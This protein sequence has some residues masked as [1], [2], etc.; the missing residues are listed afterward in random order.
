[1]SFVHLDVTSDTRLLLHGVWCALVIFVLLRDVCVCALWRVWGGAGAG[2]GIGEA[3][4][5]SVAEAL[6]SG[7]CGLTSL[8][9]GGKWRVCLRGVCVG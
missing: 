8:H 5:A 9:L 7:R 3:G 6:G 1:M 2:N 4:A